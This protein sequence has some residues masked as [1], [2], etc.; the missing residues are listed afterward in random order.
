MVK[1]NKPA[2]GGDAEDVGSIP[3]SGRSPEGGNGN[4]L[5]YSFLD[6][7]VDGGACGQQSKGHT[8]VRTH[9]NYVRYSTRS[10]VLEFAS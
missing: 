1:K 3:G 8:H 4:P 10:S 9:A 6:N 7:P 2:H 5:Q